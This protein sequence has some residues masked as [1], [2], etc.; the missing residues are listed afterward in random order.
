MKEFPEGQRQVPKQLKRKSTLQLASSHATEIWDRCQP[1]TSAHHYLVD[2]QATGVP[3]G[4]L[5]V[6]PAEDSLKIAGEFMAGSLVV[7]ACRFDGSVSSLQFFALPD[8]AKRLLARGKSANLNLPGTYIEGWHVVGELIPGGLVYISESI[9]TAWASWRATGAASVACFGWER[10]ANVAAEIRQADESAQIVL[11]PSAGKESDAVKIARKVNAATTRMPEGAPSN[12]DASDFAKSDGLEALR[13]LLQAAQAPALPP[14]MLKPVCVSDVLT[15]PSP[16]PRFVWDGYLPLGL[17][18]MFSAHGGTGKST[19]ALMLAVCTALG[20]SL[21]SI[22]TIQC[23][24][25]FVSLE[26]SAEIVR[27]RLAIICNQMGFDPSEL[28]GKLLLVDGTENP[29]LYSADVRGAGE[30]TPTYSELRELVQLNGLG[31]VVIDNASDAYG[32][33]EIQR[34]QVR[35]FLR[36]LVEIARLSNCAILLLAHVDKSTSRART[37]EAGE[38]YSGSTA[39]HNSSRSRLFMSRKENGEIKLEHQKCNLGRCREPLLLEWPVDGLP[40]L[41][42]NG[43]GDGSQLVEHIEGRADDERAIILLKM[44]AEFSSREQYCSPNPTARNNVFAMLKF[45]SAFQ[46]LKLNADACKRIV[47]QCQRAKWLE[48]IEY[49]THDRKTRLRWALT[50]KG[51]EIAGLCAP[52]APCAPYAEDGDTGTQGLVGAPSAPSW[53]GG[54]GEQSALIK[55]NTNDE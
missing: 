48:P 3:L 52:C 9:G 39:W 51:M 24:V 22:Q 16:P 29:E 5:R 31:L 1:A 54:T 37:A 4:S 46:R 44:I 45:D 53:A 21:F 7:P 36:T 40:Q 43:S 23:K 11:V 33:D 13:T 10:I 50:V 19:L 15:N 26:D 18:S 28:E 30:T 35:T 42:K 2:N 38:G 27:N 25:L 20:R 41:L 55:G 12:F 14:P 17:V 8:V 49:R 34:R 47:T 6:L 32:G